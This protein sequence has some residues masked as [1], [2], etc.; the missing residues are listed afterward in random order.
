MYVVPP[1][2]SDTPDGYIWKLKHGLYGLKDG[3]C[4]FYMSVKDELLKLGFTR[5]KLD[6]AVFT[7]VRD[8]TLQGI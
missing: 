6:P 8:E 1:V 2:E 5:S 4:Q 7:L 3:A